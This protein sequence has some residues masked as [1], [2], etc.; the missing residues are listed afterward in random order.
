MKVELWEIE[1]VHPYPGNPRVN[2]GAVD[3]VAGSIKEFGW[4]QA[5]VVDSQGVVI[6][7]HTR[8]KAAQKLGLKKVPVH[9]AERLTEAQV[10][11]YRLADNKVSELAEWDMELLPL[12]LKDLE[13]MGVDLATLGF[14]EDDLVSILGE[15]PKDGLTDPDQVPAPPEEPITRPGDIWILGEHRLM[16]GDSTKVEDVG[17][18]MVDRKADLVFTDPPWNVNYGDV[19]K[20]NAQGYK[21]RT[22]MND[23]LDAASWNCFVSKACENLSIASKPGAPIYLVMSAQEWPVIDSGLRR[24]GF[25]WSSTI[26]WAKDRLVLSRKDYHTQYEPIWYGW[27]EKAPRLCC[28]E[29]RKQS[30][31]WQI[32]RPGRSELH[33]TTKPVELI[34]RAIFNSS[35]RGSLVLDLFGGSGSTLIACERTGRQCVSMELDPRYCD[36]IRQRWEEFTGLKATR[37]EVTA[38]QEVSDATA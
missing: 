20:G 3:A 5:I 36:V 34:E 21:P 4:Q 2:E 33:P 23:H 30:D 11:A 12:E 26:I 10:K 37:E 9:V 35:N 22:M 14:S 28:V 7:G 27:N 16:C 13:G 18:L 8:L 19:E 17:R 1:S 32:Q 25:H 31:I 15:E 6:C 29:D 24:A 38:V